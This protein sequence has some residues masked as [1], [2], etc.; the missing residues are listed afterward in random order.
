MKKLFLIFLSVVFIAGCTELPYLLFGSDEEEIIFTMMN[1]KRS[2]DGSYVVKVKETNI[3]LSADKIFW[4]LEKFEKE[5]E[6]N[7]SEEGFVNDSIG[8]VVTWFDVDNN[9]FLSQEDVIFIKKIEEQEGLFDFKF[10]IKYEGIVI[11]SISV[12]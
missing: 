8:V 6:G 12:R 2:L 7:F 3:N 10:K 1:D 9:Y 4:R 11:S 5:A